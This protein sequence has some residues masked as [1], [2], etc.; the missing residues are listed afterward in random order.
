[1][2]E[3]DEKSLSDSNGILYWMAVCN[4]EVVLPQGHKQFYQKKK[5]KKKHRRASARLCSRLLQ[6]R[7]LTMAV[8]LDL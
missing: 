4:E 6:P 1:M 7:L 8:T 3:A 5:K 2:F